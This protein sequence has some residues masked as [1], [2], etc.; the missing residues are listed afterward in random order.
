MG[1]VSQHSDGGYLQ[2]LATEPMIAFIY[3]TSWR[4]L[5]VSATIKHC[6]QAWFTEAG[7]ELDFIFSLLTLPIGTVGVFFY[8]FVNY[9]F[10]SVVKSNYIFIPVFN[11]VILPTRF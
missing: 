8:F 5:F 4:K 11:F 1:T 9:A 2:L 6:G 3:P 10:T 7:K